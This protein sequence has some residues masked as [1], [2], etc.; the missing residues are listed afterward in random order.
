M[1]GQLTDS[2]TPVSINCW[3]REGAVDKQNI[4]GNTIKSRGGVDKLKVILVH[5][6]GHRQG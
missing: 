6:L 3:P 2:V 1:S 5:E 4:S